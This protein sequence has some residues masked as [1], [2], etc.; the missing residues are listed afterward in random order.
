MLNE[1]ETDFK[2]STSVPV[3]ETNNNNYEDDF[4]IEYLYYKLIYLK[5][6]LLRKVY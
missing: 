5:A 1:L 3:I 4:K 6:G 2:F